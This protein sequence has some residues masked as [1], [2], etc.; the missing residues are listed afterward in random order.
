MTPTDQARA[1]LAKVDGAVSGS[2]GHDQTFSV[3][4]ALVHGFALSEAE[5][6]DLLD[7]WNARCQPPWSDREIDHKLASALAVTNHQKP[8]GHLLR[9]PQRRQT[10]TGGPTPATAVTTPTNPK[11]APRPYALDA[12]AVIPEPIP[13]GTREL[14]RAA[15]R[16]GEGVCI[17][18]ATITEGGDEVPQGHGP[19]LHLE[20]WLAK[21][22]AKDGD[23]NRMM[24][25]SD[26][27]GIYIRVNPL[28][29]GSKSTDGDV[30]AFRHT[31]VEF[32]G[33]SPAE[34]YDLYLK[35][36]LPIT[37]V[38]FSGG[39]SVHAWV[40]VDASSRAEYDERVR[41]IY[42]H[43]AAY[44]LDPKNKNPSRLSR[45]PNC[46]RLG[47]RQ[48]LLALKI[49]VETFLDWL[50]E[51]EI[52]SFGSRLSVAA[53][54]DF[55]EDDDSTWLLGKRWLCRGGSCLWIGPS[56]VGKSSLATQAA[57]HWAVGRPF[58][59]IATRGNQPL[60][61]LVIQAENDFGDMS[62]QLCGV[63]DGCGLGQTGSEFTTITRNLEVWHVAHL[64]GR[65]FV[66][67]L[68]RII[69]RSRP[70]LVWIDPLLSYIGDDISKQEVC[71]RFLREWLQPV[72]MASGVVF[73]LVHHTGKP[74]ADKKQTKG[75]QL[76][77]LSY[78][79]MGS[80][81]LTNWARAIITIEQVGDNQF[82]LSLPKRGKRAGATDAQGNVS[83]RLGM[84]HSERGIC[85]V[86]T[87]LPKESNRQRQS[88]ADP[89]EDSTDEFFALHSGR[90]YQ[91]EEIVAAV[92]RD[93]RCSDSTARRRLKEWSEA[94]LLTHETATKRYV[95]P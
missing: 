65:P 20:E 10:R 19:T 71:S 34:Q 42:D 6:R 80:S 2:G 74:P 61:S 27:A 1:Y 57:L 18:P 33:L 81:E 83:L 67:R 44:G 9:A 95:F 64:V 45:L 91:C 70:D 43:L 39:K 90:S 31:L 63:L 47:R 13:D 4:C 68:T 88:A 29:V 92:M 14:L 40:R 49:G 11:P 48:E 66:E 55:R 58:L 3:A 5:A 86:Q 25:S 53:M 62:E 51:K 36:R 23:P 12:K 94:N 46:E 78:A 77:D 59:G 24:R 87:E 60:K 76:S 21:L 38:I 8:R 84:A 52:D 82:A 89:D 37:A 54:R 41:T 22:D 93:F 28:K 79:G 69:D 72:A 85:W 75:R 35:S 50:Q 32:D 26:G 17:V 7:G 73:M 30:T 56:G 15:F 16:P